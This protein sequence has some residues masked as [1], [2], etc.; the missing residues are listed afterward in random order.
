MQSWQDAGL[1]VVGGMAHWHAPMMGE[2]IAL[3]LR[4]KGPT[5]AAVT[6]CGALAMVGGEGSR[7]FCVCVGCEAQ[8]K[9]ASGGEW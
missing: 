1:L 5:D 6:R 3:E 2:P 9:A 7:S 8:D 4:L